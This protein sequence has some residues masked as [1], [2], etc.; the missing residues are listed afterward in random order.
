MESLFHYVKK[1]SFRF[2][3]CLS[4]RKPPSCRKSLVNFITYC[5]IDHTSSWAGFKL[6]TSVVIGTDCT[7]SCKSNYHTIT[8]TTIYWLYTF[9][10]LFL[11]IGSRSCNTIAVSVLR[12]LIVIHTYPMRYNSYMIYIIRNP[13]LWLGI[14]AYGG[15]FLS[16]YFS[17]DDVHRTTFF[18]M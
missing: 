15:G 17:R 5:W 11:K 6:T 14:S 10:V 3:W 18:V 7:D 4:W 2:L 16:V 9:C 1:L 13:I 8:T 12:P